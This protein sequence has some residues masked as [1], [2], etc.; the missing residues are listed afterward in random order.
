MK[1]LKITCLLY[2]VLMMAACSSS[3]EPHIIGKPGAEDPKPKEPEK[4]KDIPAVDDAIV[5]FMKRHNIPGA[6]LAV[7]KNSK[8]VY[9]K[10][11]GY[12]DM[13][14]KEE[15]TPEHIF[16]LASV[17]KTYTGVA[18][19]LLVE[20]NKLSLSD[21]V[22]GQGAVLGTRYGKPPYNAN[23]TAITV[24]D[25]LQNVSGSW[26][27]ATGGD[28]IDHNPQMT[29]D[30]LLNWIIGSRPNPRHPGE[31][32]DYS[33][34]NFWIAGRIIEKVS[35]K[36]Y[37]DFVKENILRPIGAESTDLAGKTPADLKPKEVKYYGQGTDLPYVYN[38]AFPRRDADGGLATTAPDLLRFV[39]AIDKLEGRPDILNSTSRAQLVMPSA[40]ANYGLGIAMWPQQSLVYNYGSL[41]GTRAGFMCHNTNGMS[42]VLLVN[43]RVEPAK[44]ESFVLDMQDTLLRLLRNN[45]NQWQAIDQF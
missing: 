42:V 13:D 10:G 3:E 43:S 32:Y 41:P 45:T 38:I 18:I 26:G 14:K 9:Q 19:L 44:E 8:L 17:S 15:V 2:I 28:V 24:K 35:G 27:A 36:S 39:N 33:N 22:F 30:E 25:L 21:K 31:L 4:Q 12:A 40:F 37:I 16:R 5:N 23:L 20:Q 6:S 29:N 1:Y 7:S 11:Y 34:I